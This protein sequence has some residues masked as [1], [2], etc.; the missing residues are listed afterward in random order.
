M[1]TWVWI[2]KL[3]TSSNACLESQC[4]A[5][6]ARRN[7]GDCCPASLAELTRSRFNEAQSQ[8]GGMEYNRRHSHHHVHTLHAHAHTHT[9]SQRWGRSRKKSGAMFYSHL[10]CRDLANILAPGIWDHTVILVH[11]AKTEKPLTSSVF[12]SQVI[13]LQ[14]LLWTWWCRTGSP[15]LWRNTR[16]EMER[17]DVTFITEHSAVQCCYWDRELS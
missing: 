2:P 6:R 7:L 4:W 8:K 1:K 9:H 3:G 14:P 16:V 13:K 5:S 11:G 10:M 12:T 17:K 15:L